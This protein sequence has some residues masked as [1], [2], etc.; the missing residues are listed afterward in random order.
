MP[1]FSVSLYSGHTQSERHKFSTAYG[2]LASGS[3]V[4]VRSRRRIAWGSGK[5][6]SSSEASTRLAWTEQLSRS[7][8]GGPGPT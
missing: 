3:T 6:S 8:E 5:H 1:L 4:E 7:P 2:P